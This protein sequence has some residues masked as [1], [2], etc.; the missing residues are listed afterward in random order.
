MWHVNGS[1]TLQY[2]GTFK[3]FRET[4]LVLHAYFFVD[5]INKY[6][7]SIAFH[8]FRQ[9]IEK[10]NGQQ[11]RCLERHVAEKQPETLMNIWSK[12]SLETHAIV[13]L[14]NAEN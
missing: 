10:H 7:M 11:L 5:M 4:Y 8:F 3:D 6:T 12:S 9:P 13:V 2:N 1:A 14:N